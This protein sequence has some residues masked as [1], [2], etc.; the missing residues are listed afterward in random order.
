M[1]KPLRRL[2]TLGQRMAA[3]GV[4]TLGEMRGRVIAP[5]VVFLGDSIT[6]FWSDEDPAFFG[7]TRLNRGIGGETTREMRARFDADVIALRPRIVHIMGGT[8]DL[9]H[10]DPGPQAT[11]A[12]ANLRWMGARAREHGIAVVLAA[13][14]PIATYA[15]PLFRAPELFTVL[16]EGIRLLTEAEG[17]TYVDY[18]PALTDPAGELIARYTTDG[19]HLTRAGYRAM[20]GT[21]Q[22]RLRQVPTGA[23]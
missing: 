14:P 12:L 11:N 8:N 22:H 20:R 21:V 15:E 13:P 16:V 2:S 7:L 1:T 18:A 6:R 9:W 19:V 10:G 5:E 23:A 17:A 4:R 3:R